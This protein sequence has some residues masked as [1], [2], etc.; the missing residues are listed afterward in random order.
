MWL[1]KHLLR[2]SLRQRS[3]WFSFL[4]SR[5]FSVE[6][7]ESEAHWERPCER[8]VPKTIQE[9]SLMLG[10]KVDSPP[11]AKLLKVA[12]IGVPN[13]GK[14]TLIN[15]LMRWRVC[16]V[17]S[18]VHTT[19]M[20]AR[21]ILNHGSKQL[22]FLDTPGIVT[23][24]EVS[25]HGLERSCLTD[26]EKSLLSAD[27]MAVVHDMSNHHTRNELHPKVLRLL[28]LYP[29]IPSILILNKLDVLKSKRHLLD[30]TRIL[31][32]GVVGGTVAQKAIETKDI[33]LDREILIRRALNKELK[34]EKQGGKTPPLINDAAD[35]TKNEETLKTHRH[36]TEHE[37]I[38]IIKDRKGWPHFQEVFMISALKALGVDDLRNYLLSKAY[39][40]PWLFSSKVVTDQ[41][42]EEI[43]LLTV[44]EKFLET[45]TKEIPYTVKFSIERWDVS[46][47][48]LMD[49]GVQVACKKQ[50]LIK[51]IV[52][53]EGLR[54]ANITSEAE[55]ELRRTFRTQVRLTINV[56]YDRSLK[57]KLY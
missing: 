11:D 55:D 14:S 57:K 9:M 53:S 16:S 32:D 48:E 26:A 23:L 36:L 27:M 43:A 31:T 24:D 21:A 46:E 7:D 45:F 8:E 52:G 1:I 10:G 37:V 50:G 39:S 18:K 54:I 34:A 29:D 28:A 15:G 13:S 42:P 33:K 19:R 12:I 20:N 17:S 51:I 49:I 3:Y 41:N 40:S 44:R 2:P 4:S 6:A 25:R 38:D 47:S 22:V 56:V 30:A 35:F 5:N